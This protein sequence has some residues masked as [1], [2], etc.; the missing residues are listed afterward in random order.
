MSTTYASLLNGMWAPEGS[1]M[2]ARLQKLQELERM[3][4]ER[5][6]MRKKKWGNTTATRSRLRSNPADSENK[7]SY[8]EQQFGSQ[9]S[10][11]YG[12]ARPK[13]SSS[14]GQDTV[15]DMDQMFKSVTGEF[16]GQPLVERSQ[17]FKT[18]RLGNS[19]SEDG[20]SS[21]R[22]KYGSG[23]RTD[24]RPTYSSKYSRSYSQPEMQ[25]V[26]IF[27]GIADS[28]LGRTT[29][30]PNYSLNPYEPQSYTRR[31]YERT[32][33]QTVDNEGD[34]Q[35]E[36]NDI[37]DEETEEILVEEETEEPV[38]FIERLE[39]GRGTDEYSH[40]YGL[41]QKRSV[42]NGLLI[43]TM[44]VVPPLKK[45]KSGENE[46]NNDT[47]QYDEVAQ[48]IHPVEDILSVAKDINAAFGSRSPTKSDSDKTGLDLSFHSNGIAQDA[49]AENISPEGNFVF[50][51]STPVNS[52]STKVSRNSAAKRKQRPSMRGKGN[53][54]D[55]FK[56][57][58]VLSSEEVIVIDDSMNDNTDNTDAS[59]VYE[60]IEPPDYSFSE[61]RKE[62]EADTDDLYTSRLSEWNI[63]DH[64][65]GTLDRMQGFFSGKEVH[66]DPKIWRVLNG[67]KVQAELEASVHDSPPNKTE[68]GNRETKSR[69]SIGDRLSKLKS[70]TDE[71]QSK[72]LSRESESKQDDAGSRYI[73]T[74]SAKKCQSKD[75]EKT[76]E[77]KAI[78]E[79][80]KSPR[81][82]VRDVRE[83]KKF[84][85]EN[86][87]ESP[88]PELE[89][90]ISV[91]KKQTKEISTQTDN[92][93]KVYICKHCGKSSSERKEPALNKT[94]G[95]SN[96]LDLRVESKNP[97]QNYSALEKKHL[98]EI[99]KEMKEGVKTTADTDSKKTTADSKNNTKTTSTYPSYMK[100][101][102]S[103]SK[104]TTGVTEKTR[105]GSVPEINKLKENETQRPKSPVGFS[106][107]GKSIVAQ[108]AKAFDAAGS[109]N[110]TNQKTKPTLS[111]CRG[112][113]VDRQKNEE[114]APKSA[115][116]TSNILKSKSME[117]MHLLS[118]NKE[119]N[120]KSQSNPKPVEDKVEPPAENMQTEK[121]VASNSQKPVEN[122]IEAAV[123]NVQIEKTGDLN[124]P[125]SPGTKRTRTQMTQKLLPPALSPKP[126]RKIESPGII[127]AEPISPVLS[128]ENSPRNKPPSGVH[129]VY[130]SNKV[131]QIHQNKL[132]HMSAG[133][134][135]HSEN[136]PPKRIDRIGQ[137]T[138]LQDS[139]FIKNDMK[140][141]NS[142]RGNKD[143]ESVWV[144]TEREGS[145]SRDSSLRRS[146]TS[147]G[148]RSSLTH[149]SWSDSGSSE[150]LPGSVSSSKGSYS[151]LQ[152]SR[153]DRRG[154][155][156]SI[157]SQNSM[158]NLLDSKG[159]KTNVVTGAK[160]TNV[161]EAYQ[162]YIS[163]K[164]SHDE[165]EDKRGSLNDSSLID[166]AQKACDLLEFE[167]KKRDSS[168]DSNETDS[169]QKDGKIESQPIGNGTRHMK[170]GAIDNTNVTEEKVG[171]KKQKKGFFKG[172]IFHK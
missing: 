121:S 104:K 87:S 58:S 21:F 62:L 163:S 134:V 131:D 5:E 126:V 128:A 164:D 46:I 67:S 73:K 38:Y 108:R 13:F 98:A 22:N 52:S 162:E 160:E 165:M 146:N 27:A 106:R 118:D 80:K 26:D 101:T 86:V 8:W 35:I 154:S 132:A 151:S 12:G 50:S 11:T 158:L 19:D 78:T 14:R 129:L 41:N 42:N 24:D 33:D 37:H 61:E 15:Q 4:K 156:S 145:R 120:S 99:K 88:T 76:N 9:L 111:L 122:K 43:G 6:A 141:R 34:E 124:M 39:N 75:T 100:S 150:S 167:P 93:E 29:E 91:E 3:R 152:R 112:S 28:V 74:S 135:S 110:N 139:P 171:K 84:I 148:E 49:N 44:P 137:F 20:L 140:R 89:T 16:L 18:E 142:L 102:A 71:K 1:E 113:S 159:T 77:G 17:N 170:N 155:V 117:Q 127:S 40:Q 103:S 109:K 161:D 92:T 81:D 10:D 149:L 30:G 82:L 70:M 96:K 59:V 119:G 36:D 53:R 51:A 83:L 47:D 31:R 85:H 57:Q 68:D 45:P 130:E 55:S 79:S 107:G 95:K 7:A 63:M 64:T 97:G 123:E 144:K 69:L 169:N 65:T 115:R 114:S 72:K 25:E 133:P 48:Y 105:K 116:A 125:P 166:F 147:A 32:I 60:L 136:T 138:T 143:G 153:S 94:E 54:V 157:T 66:E 172:K 90:Q 56:N 2:N 168:T 23:L